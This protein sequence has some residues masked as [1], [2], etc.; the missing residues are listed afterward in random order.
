MGLADKCRVTGNTGKASE[1]IYDLNKE[2]TSQ[3]FTFQHIKGLN[4]FANILYDMGDVEKA[5]VVYKKIGDIYKRESLTEELDYAYYLLDL[6]NT[7]QDCSDTINCISTCKKIIEG[8]FDAHPER[9]AGKI[10]VNDNHIKLYAKDLLARIYQNINP[11]YSAK[12]TEEIILFNDDE[13]VFINDPKETSIIFIKQLYTLHQDNETVKEVYSN[14]NSGGYL[15]KTQSSED[16]RLDFME[17]YLGLIQ[18]M[19]FMMEHEDVD[20][21]VLNEKKSELIR[22]DIL[23][24]SFEY[25][26]EEMLTNM[27]FLTEEQRETYFNKTANKFVKP[28]GLAQVGE[29]LKSEEFNG[30]IYDYLLLTKSI[31]LASSTGLSDIVYKSKDKDLIDLYEK[32]HNSFNDLKEE[33][34]EQY[35]RDIIKKS[36]E[37]SDF[38][39]V[40]HINWKDIK[41]V[42]KDNEVAL[43]FFVEPLDDVNSY[44]VLVLRNNWEAPKYYSLALVETAIE[45]FGFPRMANIWKIL[46]N[47]ELINYGDTVFMSGAGVF[48]TKWFEHLEMEPGVCFSDLCH[49]VRLTSTREIVKQRTTKEPERKSVILFGGLDYDNK[50]TAETTLPDEEVE[51]FRGEGDDRYRSGFERL[52]YSQKE[53]DAI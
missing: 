27:L 49:V 13:N 36:R 20:N 53:I 8:K 15:D 35:E 52:I 50:E 14:L 18:F 12:L 44:G 33:T 38:T 40:L 32:I 19:K 41:N 7:Y 47:E 39:N 2:L 22:T 5:I 3:T 28:F 29:A 6:A 30:I 10:K 1:Y 46:M 37:I 23:Q 26:K 21:K 16:P 48:Q 17:S 34:I 11:A 51:I 43:E 25:L 24:S 45:E 9:G 31:L 4:I 42:L